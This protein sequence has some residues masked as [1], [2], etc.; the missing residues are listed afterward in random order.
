VDGALGPSPQSARPTSSR[1]HPRNALRPL[2][3]G[4]GLGH[5]AGPVAS[6]RRPPSSGTKPTPS[7]SAGPLRGYAAHGIQYLPSARAWPVGSRLV[8]WVQLDGTYSAS[9]LP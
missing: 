8:Q 1:P 9:R 5:P 3:P 2:A 4:R 6:P 7:V